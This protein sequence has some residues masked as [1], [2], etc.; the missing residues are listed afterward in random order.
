MFA[1]KERIDVYCKLVSLESEKMKIEKQLENKTYIDE[2]S[3]LLKLEYSKLE[4]EEYEAI[5]E[6]F[7][8]SDDSEN[9]K[10]CDHIFM[11]NKNNRW[12]C[13]NCGREFVR[14]DA[15][16][17]DEK[18]LEEKGPEKAVNYAGIPRLKI[19][20]DDIYKR[21]LYL[22]G[23]IEYK[24]KNGTNLKILEEAILKIYEEDE[25]QQ[26]YI[27]EK[28]DANEMDAALTLDFRKKFGVY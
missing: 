28:V 21:L 22:R 25:K 27:D 15:A 2:E 26:K 9:Y 13:P 7:K 4:G 6:F 12:W 18:E 10:L 14:V 8:A 19:G 17:Y 20:Y 3:K 5:V 23:F 11:G 16:I 1:N 24:K